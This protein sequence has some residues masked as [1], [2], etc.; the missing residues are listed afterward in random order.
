MKI[1]SHLLSALQGK[2]TSWAVFNHFWIEV[3][4]LGFVGCSHMEIW[5]FLVVDCGEL[6]Q[7]R[8]YFMLE[9][10]GALDAQ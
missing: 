1:S 5:K 9:K 2:P 10:M 8:S 6:T 7:W 4:V 3:C